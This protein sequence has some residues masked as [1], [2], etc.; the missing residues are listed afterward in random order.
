M[1]K[2]WFSSLGIPIVASHLRNV[3]YLD[4]P[5]EEKDVIVND[6]RGDL[7]RTFVGIL[8]LLQE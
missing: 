8:I 1:E 5:P 7:S 2:L 4:H 3:R 6:L